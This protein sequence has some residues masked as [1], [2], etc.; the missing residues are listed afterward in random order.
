MAEKST[1]TTGKSADE[2]VVLAAEAEKKPA[3][4][5]AYRSD[6]NLAE[7][8]AGQVVYL[9]PRTDLGKRLLATGYFEEVE[10]P[11]A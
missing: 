4:A 2:A 9:D 11:Q 3:G 1:E 7:V 8:N 6:R 10:D 5:K